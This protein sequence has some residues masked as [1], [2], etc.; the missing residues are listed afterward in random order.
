MSS[1]VKK[2]IAIHQPN[3]LPW[4]GFFNKI[5]R[6]DLFILL[7]D[8]QFQKKG[9]TWT[10]RTKLLVNSSEFFA[11]VPIVRNYSGTRLISEMEINHST[12]WQEKILK[13]VEMSYRKSPYFRDVFFL[14]ENILRYKTPSLLDF[15]FKGICDILTF[16]GL[17]SGKLK[18]S[19]VL[20]VESTSTDRLVELVQK[21]GGAVYIV[22][23]GAEYQEDQ[24]FAAS[25]IDLEFQNFIP[26]PYSQLGANDFVPGLSI[27]D[28]LFNCGVQETK[29]LIGFDPA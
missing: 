20:S 24:K 14:F 6:C 8:V 4:Q 22:G 1:D 9:G 13:T 11:T 27:F 10:N 25:G 21:V 3:F 18:L 2:K 12:P 7:D 5:A 16:L 19:S 29:R 23:G 15:N 28:S 26:R 17:D